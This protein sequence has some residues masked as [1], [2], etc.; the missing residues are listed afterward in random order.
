M[1][2]CVDFWKAKIQSDESLDK[3]RLIIV[4][5]EYLKNKE[6]VVDTG[7]PIAS[8]RNFK[9]LLV[10]ADNHKARVHHL[11]FIEVSL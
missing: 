8:M 9:Y 6:L 4:V 7:S 1:T 11:D 2:P 10:D 3:L 5:R